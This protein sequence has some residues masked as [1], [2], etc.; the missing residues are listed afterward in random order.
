MV[1]GLVL[2]LVVGL[3]LMLETTGYSLWRSHCSVCSLWLAGGSGSLVAGCG[4]L[5][6][7]RWWLAVG[8]LLAG[9]WLGLGGWSLRLA[10]GWLLAGGGEI[11]GWRQL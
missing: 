2:V 10:V 1:L 7:A 3:V 4:W 5:G 8:W 11:R 9:W 6:S